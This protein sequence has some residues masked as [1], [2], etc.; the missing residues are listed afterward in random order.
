MYDLIG[1]F[2]ILLV[3]M[4]ISGLSANV[5][6]FLWHTS[7]EF[8]LIQFFWL[9]RKYI[10]SAVNYYVRIFHPTGCIHLLLYCIVLRRNKR[11]H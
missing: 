5:I 10:V 4:Q 1:M 11:L 3:G 7:I 2:D 9:V 8:F 6:V